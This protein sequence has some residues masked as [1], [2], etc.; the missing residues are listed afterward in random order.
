MRWMVCPSGTGPHRTVGS[1]S[2]LRSVRYVDNMGHIAPTDEQMAALSGLP[3]DEPVVMLNPTAA[4]A[5]S[6]LIALRG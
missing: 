4:V 3:I 6:R 5:D 2:L 1:T